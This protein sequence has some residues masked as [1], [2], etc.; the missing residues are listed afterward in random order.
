MDQKKP[1]KFHTTEFSVERCARIACVLLCNL[2]FKKHFFTISTNARK[3]LTCFEAEI[4]EFEKR[5]P[6][7][8]PTPRRWGRYF[9]A[10][11]SATFGRSRSYACQRVSRFKTAHKKRPRMRRDDEWRRDYLLDMSVSVLLIR[12]T[13]YIIKQ[14][15]VPHSS[16]VK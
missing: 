2:W 15:V 7:F 10:P 16:C 1:N 4:R 12:M 13:D 11:T 8:T 6:T 14:I 3:A 5:L 9:S